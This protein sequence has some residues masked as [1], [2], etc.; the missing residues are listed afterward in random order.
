MKR[1]FIPFLAL[2]TLSSNSVS[3]RPLL[4][5]HIELETQVETN[6]ESRTDIDIRMPDIEVNIPEPRRTSGP[7]GPGTW[8]R[9]TEQDN[10]SGLRETVENGRCIEEFKRL[11]CYLDWNLKK[12]YGMC[13]IVF[14]ANVQSL[15]V[16]GDKRFFESANHFNNWSTDGT[17]RLGTHEND[18]FWNGAFVNCKTRELAIGNRKPTKV[19][20]KAK[21]NEIIDFVCSL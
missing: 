7:Y 3:A 1:F 16:H 17:K 5:N 10:V 4:E 8:V 18:I 9:V 14:F 21:G 13:G 20:P 15:R 6:I 19:V 12:A 2:S 11:C